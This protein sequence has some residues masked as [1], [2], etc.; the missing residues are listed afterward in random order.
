MRKLGI[1]TASVLVVC[2]GA[3][4]VAMA[5]GPKAPLT[6]WAAPHDQRSGAL[7]RSGGAG[8]SVQI[9]RSV[10]ISAGVAD[11]GLRRKPVAS[12]H[13]AISD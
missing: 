4:V 7:P 11:A 8:S 1:V 3:I 12:R 9:P 10:A 2:L 6:N 13:V 5:G